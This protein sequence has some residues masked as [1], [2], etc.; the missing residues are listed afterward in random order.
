M[1]HFLNILRY[2]KPYKSYAIGHIISNV[3]FALFGTL[4]FISMMPML[5]VIFKEETKVPL[6]KPVYEGLTKN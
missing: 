5:K 2:A 4:S 1:N 3:F 6:Q